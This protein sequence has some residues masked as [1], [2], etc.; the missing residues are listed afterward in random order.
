MI[1]QDIWSLLVIASLLVSVIS[2][3]IPWGNFVISSHRR[4]VVNNRL[5]NRTVLRVA[6]GATFS[7]VLF[8]ILALIRQAPSTSR[9]SVLGYVYLFTICPSIF[10]LLV[11]AAFLGSSAQLKSKY[12]VSQ[13]PDIEQ[14]QHRPNKR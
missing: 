11:V 10:V 7:G 4:K 2:W 5:K 14:D 6:L 13:D 12:R 3:M 1:E 9:I 8:V